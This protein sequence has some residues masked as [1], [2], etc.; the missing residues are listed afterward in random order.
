M[1]GTIYLPEAKVTLAGNGTSIA[2]QIIADC[3]DVTG[4]G[5]LNI[6]YDADS[7]VK[8]RGT[9]LVQ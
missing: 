6:T 8:F 7:L 9:G 5:T 2:T 3:A 4:N 1:S